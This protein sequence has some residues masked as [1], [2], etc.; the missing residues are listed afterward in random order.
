M[1]C[2]TTCIL[3]SYSNFGTTPAPF[4]SPSA[5]LLKDKIPNFYVS[6]MKMM[7]IMIGC[8]VLVGRVVM[9]AVVMAV[10]VAV[11]ATVVV[12]VMVMAVEGYW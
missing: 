9:A 3:Y 10:V 7:S 11:V 5:S 8:Y 12:M 2:L 4:F 6:N 1:R